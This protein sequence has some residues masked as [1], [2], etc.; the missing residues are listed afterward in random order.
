MN[1]PSALAAGTGLAVAVA[2]AVVA[3]QAYRGYRRNDSR[4]MAWLAV[5]VVL[6][7]ALPVATEL[8]LAATGAT[9]GASALADAAFRVAGL[10]VVLYALTRA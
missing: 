4:P 3:Y 1:L 7:T 8:V 10:A 9:A 2:G 5:G 6:L